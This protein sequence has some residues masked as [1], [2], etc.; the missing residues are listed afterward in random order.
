MSA[1][2]NVI[3]PALPYALGVAFLAIL[4]L[5]NYANW[6]STHFQRAD[7]HL[8]K[9]F[10]AADRLGT[11]ETLPDAIQ[12]LLDGMVHS[13]KKSPITYIM[14]WLA[15]KG[16]IRQAVSESGRSS[17]SDRGSAIL[18]DMQQLTDEQKKNFSAALVHYIL[19]NS[20]YVPFTGTILR[21]LLLISVERDQRPVVIVTAEYQ[22]R[23]KHIPV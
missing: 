9:F 11:D 23:H 6:R 19:T 21:R 7:V 17:A 8:N 13:V 16:T 4:V 5:A 12:V 14:I 22:R 1:F 15:L 20:L 10:D 18:G 2:T 3:M